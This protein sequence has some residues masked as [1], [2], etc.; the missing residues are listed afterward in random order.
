MMLVFCHLLKWTAPYRLI[1]S[2]LWSIWPLTEAAS[3]PPP[4]KK[5]LD[6]LW[7]DLRGREDS[8]LCSHTGRISGQDALTPYCKKP[9]EPILY[10]IQHVLSSPN[11]EVFINVEFNKSRKIG[12][13]RPQKT[14]LSRYTVQCHLMHIQNVPR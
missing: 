4:T 6:K 1:T 3:P 9:P 14:Y 8:F 12:N 7:T 10:T 5:R 13:P 2:V 11:S